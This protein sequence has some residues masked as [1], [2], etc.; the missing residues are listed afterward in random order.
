[1]LKRGE[2]CGDLG[3]DGRIMRKWILKKGSRGAWS[4]FNW[5]G[6]ELSAGLF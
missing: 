6:Y 1:M 3:V 4:G 2:N 5:P